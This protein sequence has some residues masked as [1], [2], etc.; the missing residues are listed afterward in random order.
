MRFSTAAIAIL[1]S[2]LVQTA[3][4]VAPTDE[5]RDA[6][7][8]QSGYLPHFNIDPNIV[9][10]AAF[11][12]LWKIP[13]NSLEQFYAKPLTYTPLAG[14]R[15]L[16]FLASSQNWI[17]T[18]DAANG[19][20]IAS[21]QVHT[22]FLQ[23]DIGCTDIPNTIG[24]TGTPT[25]D[26]ETDT[27]Y[28]FS[29]TYS[30]NLRVSGNTGVE[31]GVYYFHGVNINTLEDVF[32][33]VLIDGR[34]ADNAPAKYFVGGVVLQRPSLT[35][36]GSVVYGAFGGHCDLFNY[37]GL[38]V[39]VNVN[40]HD[41]VAHYAMESGPLVPQTN[42]IT[43][44]GG[45]GEG[46]IW[47]AGMGLAT[48]GTDR[49]FVV[50]GNGQGH[51]NQGTPAA[52]TSGLETLGEAALN[53][54]VDPD[55][56]AV[57]LTDYFQPFDY[58]NMDGGDQDFGSG[59]IIL[60]DPTVFNGTGVQRMAVTA[61][62]NGKVYIL[63]VNDL[64]G[65][66]L[67]AGQTDNVI[68]TIVT[69]ESVF[70]AAGSYPGEGGYVYLTPVGYATYVYKLGF[71]DGGVPQ[72]SK[73]SETSQISAGR[74]GVGIP[75]IT[76]LNGQPGSAIL[77]MT[78]P[79]A[80]LRAWY[81]V[82]QNGEMVQ[83]PLPQLGGA[84]KFQRPA[85]GDGR[86]YMTDS[87]GV[88][89]CLGAPVN[90]PL[91]CTSPVD[92]GT[93]ALGSSANAT[94]TCT[95]VIALDSIVGATTGDPN[96]LV[97]NSSLPQGPVAKGATFSFPVTWD[98]TEET[99]PNAV[100]ASSG[101]VSPGFKSTPLTID[102]VNSVAGYT[103][104]FPIS[105]TGNEVSAAPF[106]ELTPATLDFGSVI[107][108]NDTNVTPITSIFTVA[109][110]GLSAMTIQGYAFTND[111][112]ADDPVWTNATQ[113]AN[114]VWNLGSAFTATGLPD[115]LSA[116]GPGDVI[117]VDATF[118]PTDGVATYGSILQIWTDG[119]VSHIILEGSA[120]L[121]PICTMQISDADGNWLSPSNLLMDF[122]RV[123]PGATGSRQIRICNS[124]GSSLEISKSKPP[125]GVFHLSDP[126]TELYE[127]QQIPVSQ[128]ALATVLMTTNTEVY[129]EPDLA[130]N[131]TWTLN[132]N[133][134]TF[135]VH[136]VE[137]QVTVADKQ[138]GPV[139]A[140]TGQPIYQY[141][142]CFQ[143]DQTGPRLFP[144]E[145]LQPNKNMT[146]NNCQ[147]ACF[148]GATPGY[149]FAATEFADECYCGNIP[150]PLAS[151]D[152]TGIYCNMACPGD[153]EDGCG[154]TGYLSVFY[155][156]N[157]YTAGADPSLYGPQTVLQA[158]NYGYIG[159]YS[160][161]TNG[162]ALS[163]FEP[164]APSTGFTIELC[165]SACTGYQFF[166]MEY[167]NQ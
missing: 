85:F 33:P 51:E 68:Q 141:L 97:S 146:N 10:S 110:E 122:G 15:Q 62:K 39:G 13:F 82:P 48:D 37:T 38:I 90:L 95:A 109:N 137:I 71:T 120:A 139:N 8:E 134:L 18:L 126:G 23:S 128:C 14:G 100:N 113:D 102:T 11:G 78:D 108:L 98:L 83:I 133:D 57:S 81:A 145:I 94:V 135:G 43:E 129:N 25:I 70:G 136:V 16:L 46:G 167:A 123:A 103:T 114:G 118:Y 30:P 154:G 63:N 74:I 55:T 164:T 52:G 138:V 149:A 104:Q 142:G 107:L 31:N 140:T 111:T 4:G 40:T 66:K 91:N 89:Y 75:T 96:F 143:E 86:V 2:T 152:T 157:L 119:G 101:D 84:N 35:Q 44:D 17:R 72:F 27:V 92:F 99:E 65:Y 24:I 73:V 32:D 22:P 159:C 12:Q 6:D 87:N 79:N 158:G 29:K 156:P 1:A 56:G 80:G 147:E 47:M 36:I 125:N 112:L 106:L 5:Y 58:Q 148:N 163:A 127:S 161:A 93:V 20:I 45:G 21:R 67:G 166:G 50:T 121:P 160:E 34:P 162:R 69:S 19:T 26:P 64:G 77:W 59:G 151:Q 28:F 41:V 155:N 54:A 76:S 9:D 60:L 150:P 130:I 42:V 49:L 3:V 115:V 105:L 165:A 117:D 144:N 153:P 131:N 53:F 61:G 132:T 7:I 116:V 88:L 124:G